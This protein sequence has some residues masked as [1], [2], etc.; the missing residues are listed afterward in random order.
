[1]SVPPRTADDLLAELRSLARLQYNALPDLITADRRG[2]ID[3][4]WSLDGYDPQW[5]PPAKDNLNTRQYAVRLAAV[6]RMYAAH[7]DREGDRLRTDP[8][9]PRCVELSVAP[10]LVT[11]PQCGANNGN[12]TGKLDG[13]LADWQDPTGSGWQCL[14]PACQWH[15]ETGVIE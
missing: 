8:L 2:N 13:F 12:G 14:N 9:F 3:G 10:A 11:C 1:M 15:S 5:V 7:P 4:A 6:L